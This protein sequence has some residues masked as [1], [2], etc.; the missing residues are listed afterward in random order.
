[1]LS[2]LVL[3][4]VTVLYFADSIWGISNPVLTIAYELNLALHR[5]LPDK[6][7]NAQQYGSVQLAHNTNTLAL[8]VAPI[9]SVVFQPLLYY[10]H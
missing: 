4:F 2:G 6:L 1:M 9:L 5:T 7:S 10:V 8:L 3:S